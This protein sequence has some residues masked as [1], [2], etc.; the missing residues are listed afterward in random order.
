MLARWQN[1][2]NMPVKP[3]A[4]FDRFKL[5]SRNDSETSRSK[6]SAS[7]RLNL[8]EAASQSRITAI[9]AAASMF[10]AIRPHIHRAWGNVVSK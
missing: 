10:D 4:I 5:V 9:S 2:T 1:G 6:D 8:F 3:S 7:I